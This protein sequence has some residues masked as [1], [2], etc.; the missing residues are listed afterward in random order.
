MPLPFDPQSFDLI[1]H[2]DVIE[3]TGKPYMF[4][5]E[6]YRVLRKGGSLV[7]GTPNLF[8]PATIL[9]LFSGR[10]EFPYALGTNEGLGDLVPK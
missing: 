2:Q 7:F 1:I 4:L 9:K 3:H 6:Q 8:R 10:L 5:S